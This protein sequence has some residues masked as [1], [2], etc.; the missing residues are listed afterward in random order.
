MTVYGPAMAATLLTA[1]ELA[2]TLHCHLDHVYRLA[3]SGRIPHF[4]VGH[5][6]RFDVEAVL[7]ALSQRSQRSQRSRRNVA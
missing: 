6:Y 1:K 3:R 7:N 4:K 5:T 2:Q